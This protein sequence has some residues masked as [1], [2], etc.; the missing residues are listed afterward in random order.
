MSK[1]LWKAWGAGWRGA[2]QGEALR[3]ARGVCG[4]GN[5]ERKPT[6]VAG[7]P[8]SSLGLT[9]TRRCTS[10]QTLGAA[11]TSNLL[12]TH[13]GGIPTPG[14]KPGAL[15]AEPAPTHLPQDASCRP[16]L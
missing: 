4:F 6:S 11:Q 12:L 3:W 1:S 16:H 15:S 7:P 14:P 5:G 13:S 8:L 9:R 2:Q 10:S